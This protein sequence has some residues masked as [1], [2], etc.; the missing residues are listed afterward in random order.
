MVPRRLLR[1]IVLFALA[2]ALPLPLPV[3]AQAKPAEPRPGDISGDLPELSRRPL[4]AIETEA[5]LTRAEADD[6][7]R[8]VRILSEAKDSRRE[9]LKTRLS[10]LYKL[11]QGGFVRLV[12]GAESLPE[13]FIRRDG[14]RR[15]LQRD[16]EELSALR[17]ELSELSGEQ[18]ELSERTSRLTLLDQEAARARAK[19]QAGERR[20]LAG[21]AKERGALHR[22]VSP[23]TI[24][25]VFGRRPYDRGLEL[26]QHGVDLSADPGSPVTAIADGQVR[27]TGEVPGLGRGVILEHEGGYVSL[28]ARVD[29]TTVV[30]G[31]RV[32]GGASLGRA[33]YPRIYFQLA[34]GDL[35]LDPGPWFGLRDAPKDNTDVR[36]VRRRPGGSINN[37]KAASRPQ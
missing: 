23:G 16:M 34:L 1:G 32:R 2:L 31:D 10:A 18:K 3:S 13:L 36:G 24:L 37:I 35:P 4:D 25:S 17:D 9:H 26:F 12:L 20:Q 5:R 7:L 8:R 33:P 27:F 19:I 15:I 29:Q 11:S 30:A 22:P 14:A 21:L 28:Y 6:L